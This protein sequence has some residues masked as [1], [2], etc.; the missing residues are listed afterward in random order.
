MFTNSLLRSKYSSRKALGSQTA[1]NIVCR[2]TGC[3]RTAER[4]MGQLSDY[5]EAIID[6]TVKVKGQYQGSQIS[7]LEQVIT[8][9][10][11]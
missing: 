11:K 7:I 10:V 9:A 6:Y 5:V 4:L 2:L 1:C 8:L 3:A